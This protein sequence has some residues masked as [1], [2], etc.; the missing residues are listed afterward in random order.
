[1]ATWTQADL[2]TLKAAVASGVLSVEYSGPPAR[3]VT[4]HGLAEM[5]SLLAEMAASVE[6]AAGTRSSYKLAGHRKGL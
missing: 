6:S 5:R 1:M 3:R 2:D 4:Y